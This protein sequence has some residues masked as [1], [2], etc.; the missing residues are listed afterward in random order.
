[1]LYDK[2]DDCRRG[3]SVCICRARYRLYGTGTTSSSSRL[4]TKRPRVPVTSLARVD[5]GRFESIIVVTATMVDE[6]K[7][8]KSVP[9]MLHPQ[10]SAQKR[11]KR[12]NHSALRLG[13]TKEAIAMIGIS[14]SIRGRLAGDISAPVACRVRAAQPLEGHRSL[15]S[16]VY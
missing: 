9:P 6:M 10:C 1:M 15:R 11:V 4:R 8:R 13:G 16:P 5:C 14:L 7:G 12:S 3:Q 2:T